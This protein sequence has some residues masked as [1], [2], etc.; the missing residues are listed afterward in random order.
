[1]SL[2]IKYTIFLCL[3]W[4]FIFSG[5]QIA[6]FRVGGRVTQ[7]CITRVWIMLEKQM[8]YQNDRGT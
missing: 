8:K 1:M 2:D 7:N 6:Y 3:F 4:V 5:D